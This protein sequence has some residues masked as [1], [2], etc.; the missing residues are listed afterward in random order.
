MTFRRK[1]IRY[2]QRHSKVEGLSSLL[3]YMFCFVSET[4]KVFSNY[5]DRHNGLCRVN[6]IYDVSI[7]TSDPKF[8]EFVLSSNKILNKGREYDF[9][10]PWLGE[11]LLTAPGKTKIIQYV[12]LLFFIG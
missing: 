3:T 9:L 10:H 4:M 2:L 5:L 11:G 7:L 1:L 6:F 8:L 12:Y